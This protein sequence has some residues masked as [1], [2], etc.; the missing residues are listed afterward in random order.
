VG[1][2]DAALEFYGRAFDFELRGR[3][4]RMAFLDMGDQFLAI[5]ETSQT[6]ADGDRHFG[7][8]VDDLDDAR[9]RLREAGADIAPGRGL[10]F[11]DP[12]GN[13]VQVVEYAQVQFS[14]TPAVLGGMGLDGLEKTPAAL[15]ELRRK[16]LGG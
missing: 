14:K 13:H 2:L 10:D 12:W 6:A 15:E 7:L 4:P 11:R 8:V 5:A 9:R 3:G 1:D 16:G